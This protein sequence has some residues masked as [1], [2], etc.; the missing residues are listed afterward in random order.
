MTSALG[1]YQHLDLP[2]P[3]KPATSPT[4]L[5]VYGGASAVGAFAIKLA[6]LSNIHPIIT[7][8]GKGIPF[9]EKL[10]DPTKGDVIIDYREGRDTVISKIREAAATA[11]K[12]IEHALDAVSETSTLEMIKQVIDQKSGKLTT[13]L[14][15]DTQALEGSQ[16]QVTRTMVGS[17]HP[18][19][20]PD[21][22]D[23]ADFGEALY[24]F[25]GRGLARG[26][27]SGHPYK[28]VSGGLYGVQKALRDLKAGK[29]SAVKYVVRIAETEGIEK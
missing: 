24:Q 20:S 21:S 22:H 14:P 28:V 27:F 12:P 5:L 10:I 2:L 25:I 29:A 8:A 6:C 3:W 19:Y 1:L 9:V 23:D 11:G 15:D 7:V 18:K 26:S 17:V 16:I 4:P 13:V